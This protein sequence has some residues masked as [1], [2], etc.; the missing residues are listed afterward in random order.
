MFPLT[1]FLHSHYECG[2]VVVLKL[3][4]S[5]SEERGKKLITHCTAQTFN[6][7][8]LIA[9]SPALL[10]LMQEH[11]AVIKTIRHRITSL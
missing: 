1:L 6:H 11:F 7:T 9:A 8:F 3:L 5:I 4:F 10:Y 2:M